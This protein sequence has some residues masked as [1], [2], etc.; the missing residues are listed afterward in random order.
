MLELLLNLVPVVVLLILGFTIGGFVERRHLASL[1]DREAELGDIMLTDLKT[2]PPNCPPEPA[3]MVIGEVVIASDYFK[4]FSAKL[5]GIIGGEMRTFQT[6]LVRGRR[7]AIV[8]M[9]EQAKALGANQVVNVRLATSSV[10]STRRKKGAAMAEVIAYG[11]AI[12]VP[13][14][15]SGE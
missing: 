3:S 10:G 5:R 1:D 8:R 15:S 9:V 11:T 6:L 12:F 14:T 13:P 4:T 2:I 7:E